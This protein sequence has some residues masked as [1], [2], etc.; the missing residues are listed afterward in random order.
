M[1][2]LKFFQKKGKKSK[3]DINIKGR[4]LYAQALAPKVKEILKLKENFPNLFLKK[5]KD[6]HNI[7]NDSGKVKPRIN[8]TTKG[9]SR[10]Q[11]IVPMSNDDI[12]K[13][14]TSSSSHIA[15]LN[16]AFKNIKSEIVA[17]FICSDQH[18]LIITT[19]K[20]TFPSDLPTIENYIKNVNNIKSN[21]IM[22]S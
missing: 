10:R 12:L 18:G 21:N 17:D 14:M 4:Y 22:T 5:I 11:I 13:F 15:N 20:V 2:K 19:N 16:S 1:K 3:E 7:I 8:I 9:L 6:I